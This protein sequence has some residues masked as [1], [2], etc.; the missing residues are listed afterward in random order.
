MMPRETAYRLA[1]RKHRRGDPQDEALH[2]S[3]LIRF[4]A[5]HG[6][7]AAR[8]VSLLEQLPGVQISAAS[9]PEALR[10]HYSL[11][12]HSLDELETLLEDAGFVLEQSFHARLLR[13][14]TKFCEETRLRNM[15][16]PQRLIKQSNAV[17]IEAWRHHPHGDHDD[18]PAELR[19]D[20]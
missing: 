11:A 1:G 12:L 4:E 14:L 16:S 13:G 8:A 10:V 5:S 19:A 15:R 2:C 7:Q 9:Q 20:K 17:Y 3:H 18:T 6:A